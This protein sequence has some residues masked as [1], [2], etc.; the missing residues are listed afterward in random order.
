MVTIPSY[1][2]G[3][4]NLQDATDNSMDLGV[5]DDLDLDPGAFHELVGKLLNFSEPVS[6]SIKC[7]L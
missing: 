3:M 1:L 7:G 6:S 4:S 5:R 2:N